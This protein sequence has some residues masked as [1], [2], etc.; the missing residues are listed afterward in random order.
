M[1]KDVRRLFAA[2]KAAKAGSSSLAASAKK[3]THPLAKYDP[4]TMRLS[5]AICGPAAPIKSDS[6]W[7]A[8]L[9]S[10]AH[11]E[12]V[13]KLRA[14]KEQMQKRELAEAERAKLQ[15]QQQQQAGVKRKA[16][17]GG[18][19]GGL[20]GLVAYDDS[21]SESDE[22]EEGAEPK[23]PKIEEQ[24]QSEPVE[25]NDSEGE[26][27][28]TAGLPAGFFDSSIA[29]AHESTEPETEE[30]PAAEGDMEGVL[31]AGFFD[32][33]EEDARIRSEVGGA[34][35]DLQQRQLDAEFKAL[36]AELAKTT[37][38]QDQPS[39][40]REPG[41]ES[42]SQQST[43]VNADQ[44]PFD[45]QEE[46]EDEELEESVLARTE[47][48]YQL[49][50]EMQER[51]EALRMKKER[52]AQGSSPTVAPTIPKPKAKSSK[53]KSIL[54]VVREQEQARKEKE[55][56]AA[57]AFAKLKGSVDSRMASDDD[58]EDDSEDD[59][60]IEAMMDWRARRV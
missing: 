18:G 36:Q 1:S 41:Q 60:D 24:D 27:D 35:A 48:E 10:K 45:A 5:C 49:F 43:S 52:I 54:D 39:Q 31:P 42:A 22:E 16:G 28:V 12:A 7:N 58:D 15:Q 20:G 8:H 21:E 34:T 50:V 25:M 9:V 26:E 13:A 3:V 37:E 40:P 19:G 57:A 59:E 2:Q 44:T 30:S 32:D 23:R 38:T 6:L 55:R 47:E 11:Q 33:P 17:S 29:E 56:Q 53:Q 51:L 46:P 14:V 4:N